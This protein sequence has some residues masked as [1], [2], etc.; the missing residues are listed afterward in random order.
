MLASLIFLLTFAYNWISQIFLS[1]RRTEIVSQ[2][3]NY[4]KRFVPEARTILFGSEARGEAL[5]DSDIDLLI[6]LPDSVQGTQYVT[7]RSYISGLLYELSLKTGV[8]ISPII[9]P[10]NIWYSRKTP[11]TVNVVNEG[12]EL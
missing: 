11:F 3:A 4:M 10:V 9:L 7:R 2:I 6:L 8:D 5:L 1:M 12:I